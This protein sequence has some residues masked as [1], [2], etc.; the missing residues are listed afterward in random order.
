MEN[1]V[2][3]N[4]LKAAMQNS[5]LNWDFENARIINLTKETDDPGNTELYIVFVPLGEYDD[6]EVHDVQLLRFIGEKI[7]ESLPEG[8]HFDEVHITSQNNEFLLI[9]NRN[10]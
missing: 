2:F 3:I 7:T 6:V 10:K 5:S 1:T 9:I 4:D 8:D